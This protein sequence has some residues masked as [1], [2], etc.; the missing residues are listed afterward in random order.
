M[1]HICTATLNVRE[2]TD[3][4]SERIA[5]ARLEAKG[6]ILVAKGAT[7]IDGAIGVDGGWMAVQYL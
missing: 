5:I 3:S 6:V 4:N 2:N 1:G 7:R